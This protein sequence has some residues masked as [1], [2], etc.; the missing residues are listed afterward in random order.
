MAAT[1]TTSNGITVSG[2]ATNF[3]GSTA[4]QS[5]SRTFSGAFT[6]AAGSLSGNI[7]LGVAT[8]ENGGAR[9]L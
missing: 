2:S 5:D 8:Q 1:G 3:D 4:S 9:P 6:T 7:A